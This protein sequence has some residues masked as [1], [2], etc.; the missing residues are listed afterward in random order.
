MMRGHEARRHIRQGDLYKDFEFDASNGRISAVIG[1][2]TN[3]KT[4]AHTPDNTYHDVWE[5]AS[6]SIEGLLALP[7]RAR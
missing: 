2:T 3:P 1:L 7:I 6:M 5:E 4:V